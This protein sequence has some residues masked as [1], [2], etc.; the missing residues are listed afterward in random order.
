MT[1][2]KKLGLMVALAAVAGCSED[3]DALDAAGFCDEWAARACSEE[4]VSACQVASSEDCVQGQRTACLA[5]LPGG[6][7]SDARAGQCLDAVEA[8]LEDADLTA[9]E[10]RTTLRLDAPCDRLVAGPAD[11]GDACSADSDCDAPAGLT[12]VFR[13]QAGSCQIPETVQPGLDCSASNAVCTEG[14]FCNGDNCIGTG[15]E[16]DPC[17]RDEECSMGTFC[18]AA[19]TCQAGLEIGASCQLDA[20]CATGICLRFSATEQACTDRLRL[21]RSEPLCN[22]FR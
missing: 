22:D 7:F 12:C 13:G 1:K 4:V 15:D 19:G 10:L 14:F 16:G 6:E 9:D 17:L 3:D 18:D 5:R 21:S 2:A 8:A 20:E 11:E